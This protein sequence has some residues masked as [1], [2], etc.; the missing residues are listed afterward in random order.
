MADDPFAP[1]ELELGRILASIEPAARLRFARAVARRLRQSQAQRI[2][3][4]KNPDGSAFTPRKNKGEG[5]R[6]RRGQ[7]KRRVAGRAMFRKL[8]QARWLRATAT[9]DEA[10]VG[11]TAAAARIGQ[12]HQLGL[13]DRVSR[14]ANAPEVTYPQRILLGLT[15]DEEEMA[16]AMAMELIAGG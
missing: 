12:V 4:Q 6:D 16:M 9:A 3:Q 5:A 8:R 7:I 1:L 13:R 10:V 11:F 14:K 15:P 2:A